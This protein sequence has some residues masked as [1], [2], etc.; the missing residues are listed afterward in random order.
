MSYAPFPS[1]TARTAADPARVTGL[2]LK[3]A[4]QIAADRLEGRRRLAERCA[5]RRHRQRLTPRDD[6]A[7]LTDRIGAA[8]A[9][10]IAPVMRRLCRSSAEDRISASALPSKTSEQHAGRL[11]EWSEARATVAAELADMQSQ[12]LF[13]QADQQQL[14]GG[15]HWQPTDR[16]PSPIILRNTSPCRRLRRNRSP[17]PRRLGRSRCRD[18]PNWVRLSRCDRSR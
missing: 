8:Q 7:R 13:L 18:C 17:S 16:T 15:T 9:A 4:Q 12:P 5:R 6:I 2:R 1:T 3:D 10:Y 11:P 14:G